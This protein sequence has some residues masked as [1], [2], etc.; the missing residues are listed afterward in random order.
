MTK[1]HPGE[2]DCNLGAARI[3]NVE[4]NVRLINRRFIVV[5]FV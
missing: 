3:P 2:T 1:R 4:H 5:V